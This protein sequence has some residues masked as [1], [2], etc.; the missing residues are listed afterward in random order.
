[1][2]QT[3]CHQPRLY[4]LQRL[5]RLPRQQRHRQQLYRQQCCKVCL[6]GQRDD[7]ALVPCGRAHFCA[8]CVDRIVDILSC[9]FMSCIF[10]LCTFMPYTFGPSFSCPAISCLAHSSKI[11]PSISCPAFS[12][13]AHWSVNF[14]SCNFSQPVAAPQQRVCG[15][16]MKQVL[17]SV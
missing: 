11:G 2:T 4:L 3:T 9:N 16:K 8:S 17:E 13:P 1:M 12:C 5:G 10:R 14:M 6:L 7:V 15:L